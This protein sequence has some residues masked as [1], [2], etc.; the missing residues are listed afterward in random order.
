[1]NSFFM[2]VLSAA[3]SALLVTGCQSY[4]P[5]PI[6]SKAMRLDWQN[7]S[8]ALPSVRAFADE[9][10]KSQASAA[11]Y[12]VTNGIDIDEAELLALLFN[13]DLRKARLEA[14]VARLGSNEAGRWED[15][16]FGLDV[17]RI[18]SG[19][20][21]PWVI[22]GL[23]NLTIPLSGRLSIERKLA[24]SESSV[25]QLRVLQQER[26]VVSELHRNWSEYSATSLSLVVITQ[27]ID[28][29]TSIESAAAKLRDAGEIDPTDARLFTIDLAR[30]QLQL[31]SARRELGKLEAHLR[32]LMGLSPGAPITIVPGAGRATEIAMSDDNHIRLLVARAEY[33]VAERSLELEIRKQYPDLQLG[34]GV[35]TDEGD[36]RLLGGISIPIPLLNANRK[37]IVEARVKRDVARSEFERQ[38]I[39]FDSQRALAHAELLAAQSQLR[40]IESTL[41]PLVDQQL[42]EA[43]KLLDIGE[44]NPLLV[45]EAIDAA[46]QTRLDLVDAGLS[47]GLAAIELRF[48]S[49]A[50][51]SS[52]TEQKQ[53]GKHP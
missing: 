18:I 36:S 3:L 32:Q 27:V 52:S 25:A 7:R 31:Q 45:R 1:M 16:S 23:V 35:G 49:E 26:V 14:D 53:S 28:D 39:S 12:D 6:D 24:I 11:D 30:R 4:T 34:L 19:A 17:E 13:P 20:K 43:K 2:P 41:V 38:L 40:Q 8:P 22:G 47:A 51:S 37:Y 10:K 44:F 29:L 50:M 15:P 21:D 46:L 9:M 5:Q 48:L 33:D 42:A